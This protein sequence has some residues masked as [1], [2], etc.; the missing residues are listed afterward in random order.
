VD[1]ETLSEK[2][3]EN[4]QAIFSHRSRET[5]K[6]RQALGTDKRQLPVKSFHKWRGRMPRQRGRK[7]QDREDQRQT[8]TDIN[9]QIKKTDKDQARQEDKNQD[10]V[11]CQSNPEDKKDETLD[12]NIADIFLLPGK[13]SFV[14]NI[15]VG[16]KYVEGSLPKT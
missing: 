2:L 9:A 7:C 11:S 5:D 16:L 1:N 13:H 8:K 6:D 10:N 3:E 12:T 14:E 15:L 4:G